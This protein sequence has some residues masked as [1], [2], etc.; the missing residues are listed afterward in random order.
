MFFLSFRSSEYSVMASISS[1]AIHTIIFR[2]NAAGLE[3]L[4]LTCSPQRFLDYYRGLCDPRPIPPL[5]TDVSG[6]GAVLTEGGGEGGGGKYLFSL[7][8]CHD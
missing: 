4:N 2:P 1:R 3:F 5:L 8:N 7:T 6:H